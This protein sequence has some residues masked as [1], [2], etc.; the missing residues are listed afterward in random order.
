MKLKKIIYRKA[1][2]VLVLIFCLS[3]VSCTGE[4]DDGIYT[5]SFDYGYG[6]KVLTE[7]VED[8]SLIAAPDAPMRIGYEFDGW[9]IVAED[10]EWQWDFENN[11]V[12][13]NVTLYARWKESSAKPY[14]L[15]LD[16]NGGT[17]S[18][19]QVEV[20]YNQEYSLPIPK[21]E[22]YYFLGWMMPQKRQMDTEGVYT[23]SDGMPLVATW[24]DYP[25]NMIIKM[26]KFEQDND[27][28]NGPEELEWQIVKH[29]N[30]KY[31]LISRHI[32]TAI[33]WVKPGDARSNWKNSL[34]CEW[35]NGEFYDGVFSEEEKEYIYL[36]DLDEANECK[37]FCPYD[38]YISNYAFENNIICC[39]P[40]PYALEMGVEVYSFENYDGSLSK[41]YLYY[42]LRG[43]SGTTMAASSGYRAG[44]P[45]VTPG[46][47]P[48]MWVSEEFVESFW[49]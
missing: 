9:W 6:D 14:I 19:E 20:Y 25:A 18:A 3:A 28:S 8:G 22:G 36:T 30:G 23:Y 38:Y 15:K 49:K 26:G 7:Q 16:P 27:L 5:V 13:E 35:L 41:T 37:I 10:E 1:A 31:L 42:A 12:L 24:G 21:K 47:R 46:I 40:T 11:I 45:D 29:G 2:L 34:V 43:T 44:S 17:C 4:K 39:E 33:S 32:L 48:A